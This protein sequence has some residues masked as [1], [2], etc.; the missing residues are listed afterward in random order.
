MAATDYIGNELEIFQHAKRWKSYWGSHIR[1]HVTGSVLEVGGGIGATARELRDAGQALWV[2]LEPDVRLAAEMRRRTSD[3]P[4][5]GPVSIVSGSI[6]S[7]RSDPAFDAIV[8][9]DVLEHID[10]DRGELIEAAR[11]LRPG[12]R[13]IVLSPAHQFLFS[14]FDAAIGHYRRYSAKDLEAITPEGLT[15]ESI[16]YLDSVGMLASLANRLLLRS[17]QPTAGQIRFWDTFLVP[18]S[19]LLDPLLGHRVGK[20]VVGVWLK[21]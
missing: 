1:R 15:V 9:I 19:R 11:R 2:T 4:L 8:Y 14:E 7:L 3:D 20:S 18:P 6:A 5:D 21:N 10:D 12:G 16:C 17:G 13:L